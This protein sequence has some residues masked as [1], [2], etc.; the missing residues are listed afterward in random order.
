MHGRR[1]RLRSGHGIVQ[2]RLS[3]RAV[4]SAQLRRVRERLLGRQEL[5][6]GP[7]RVPGG[8]AR[9][10][11]NLHVRQHGCAQLRRLRDRLWQ[12]SDLQRG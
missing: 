1:L 11:R 5:L 4:R 6:C 9:L 8:R 10:R 12:G 7:L 3:E 2:W